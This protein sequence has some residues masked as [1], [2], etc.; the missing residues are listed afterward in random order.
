MKVYDET[1]RI[2]KSAVSKGRLGRE[3]ELAALKRLD[4]QSRRLERYVTGPDLKEIVAGEFRTPRVSAGAAYSAGNRTT[5]RQPPRTKR[6]RTALRRNNK[7][8]DRFTQLG[9]VERTPL[10]LPLR[11]ALRTR[12]RRRHAS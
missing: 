7:R 11:M 5:T 9:R 1:I 10:S 4:E 6:P 2:M 12:R 3:E 8:S